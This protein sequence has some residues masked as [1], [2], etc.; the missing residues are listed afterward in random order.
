MAE[1]AE[2]E[3][4]CSSTIDLILLKEEEEDGD[5]DGEVKEDKVN[6]GEKE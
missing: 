5:G 3:N 1:G 4:P 2:F 6:M